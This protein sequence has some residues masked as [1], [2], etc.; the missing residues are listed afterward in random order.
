M[1]SAVGRTEYAHRGRT[2]AM[3][4]SCLDLQCRQKC[5][6]RNLHLAQLFHALLPFLL[7]TQQLALARDVAAIAFGHDVLA[8]GAYDLACDDAAANGGLD[9]DLEHLPWDEVFEAVAQ[10]T[11]PVIGF[12]T[13]DDG[14]QRIRGITVNEDI[15]LHQVSRAH[16]F[17]FV[18]ERGIA[19][20]D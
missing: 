1:G 3:D 5:F 14:G 15:E 11:P 13:M 20:R 17:R 2:C 4:S 16:S 19:T 6:L 12:I 7:P 18:V 8:E 9:D 10:L